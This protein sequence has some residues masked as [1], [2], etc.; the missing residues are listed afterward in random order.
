MARSPTPRGYGAREVFQSAFQFN[1]TCQLIRRLNHKA[2]PEMAAF[3][4]NPYISMCALTIELLLKTFHAIQSENPVPGYHDLEK[5]YL[6]LAPA[7][8]K[9]IQQRWDPVFTI[10]H[11]RWDQMRRMAI[12]PNVAPLSSSV[13]VAF[14]DAAKAFEQNRYRFEPTNRASSFY[15]DDLRVPLIELILERQP[16]FA[17]WTIRESGMSWQELARNYPDDPTMSAATDARGDPTQK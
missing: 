8:Q 4:G 9:A 6:G 12:G 10:W 3:V 14:R 15:I 7:T 11:D 16:A 2:E 5:L 17:A 1:T 13:A